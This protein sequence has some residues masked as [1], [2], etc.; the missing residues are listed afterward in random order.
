MSGVE[1][2]ARASCRDCSWTQAGQPREVD[3]AAERHSKSERHST[4]V[5]ATPI[6]RRGQIEYV[7][8]AETDPLVTVRRSKLTQ[9]LQQR[10]DE[11]TAGMVNTEGWVRA[12]VDELTRT[13]DEPHT[14]TR[15]MSN[16]DTSPH[17]LTVSE[18][19]ERGAITV[20]Q[21]AHLLGIGRTAAY[22]AARTGT[23]PTIRLG[24]RVLVPVP[25]LLRMLGRS[26]GS[27]H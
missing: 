9:L 12:V 1:L 27:A 14:T 23:I 4:I 24:R 26:S 11:L 6:P 19:R 21:A 25:A 3:R 10:V 16:H 2:T 8:A 5:H 15:G 18:A 22:D 20:E 17:V 7:P 13:E